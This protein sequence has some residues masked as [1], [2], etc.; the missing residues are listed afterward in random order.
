MMGLCARLM[1]RLGPRN[2]DMIQSNVRHAL[3]AEATAAEIDAVARCIFHNLLKNYFD[4]L[5]LPAQ[6][7]EKI[8]PL[9]KIYGEEHIAEAAA[10]NKGLIALSIHLGNVELMT[11]FKAI[12]D[13]KLNV[14]A[15]HIKNERLY[16]YIVSLRQSPGINIIP[17]DTGLREVFRALKRNEF[18]GLVFDRDVNESG[19]VIPFFG[20]PARLPDG[21]AVLA[22]KLGVPVLPG[23]VV[24][25]PDGGYAL[26]LDEPMLFEGQ[27]SNDDDVRRVMSAVVPVMERFVRQFMDQW[28]YFHYVWEDDKERVRSLGQEATSG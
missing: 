27:A 11:Q 24:R 28:V 4:L 5:W 21:Y 22:L 20:S 3:G 9:V 25:T 17:V 1:Y 23:V 15:E 2:R 6:K 10:F 16:Q 13:H 14:V 12:T 19:R 26:Y 7:R 8:A 18:V